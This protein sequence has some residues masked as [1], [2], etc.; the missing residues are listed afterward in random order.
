MIFP[1][2]DPFK[3]EDTLALPSQVPF[4][5]GFWGKTFLFFGPLIGTVSRGAGKTVAFMVGP[6]VQNASG[7]R[8]SMFECEGVDWLTAGLVK[9]V[10]PW[11]VCLAGQ[12][13]LEVSTVKNKG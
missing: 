9:H 8:R 5:A 10:L 12:V 7:C 3:A 11:F 13:N 1:S 2:C 6:W 4:L